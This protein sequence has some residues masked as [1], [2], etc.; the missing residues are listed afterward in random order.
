MFYWLLSSYNW[1]LHFLSDLSFSFLLELNCILSILSSIVKTLVIPVW[2][3]SSCLWL[4]TSQLG[5]YVLGLYLDID[6]INLV[7]N[8]ILGVLSIF[9]AVR[10]WMYIHEG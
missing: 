7:L 1:H 8:Y 6:L 3:F 5:L 9:S 4:S 10:Y 2:K